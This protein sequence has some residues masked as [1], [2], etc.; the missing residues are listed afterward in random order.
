MKTMMKLTWMSFKCWSQPLLKMKKTSNKT[1]HLPFYETGLSVI[2]Q[3]FFID[4]TFNNEKSLNE[5]SDAGRLLMTKK[6]IQLPSMSKQTLL[7][8]L[9]PIQSLLTLLSTRSCLLRTLVTYNIL[10]NLFSDSVTQ[11]LTFKQTLLHLPSSVLH[12]YPI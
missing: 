6:I 2:E 12:L 10:Y 3:Y 11:F 4:L 7:H 5:T 8:L 1:V 9:L